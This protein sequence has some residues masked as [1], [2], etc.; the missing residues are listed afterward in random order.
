MSVLTILTADF[1]VKIQAFTHRDEAYIQC[2]GFKVL[3]VKGPE[4]IWGL[5]KSFW[6]QNGFQIEKIP[7]VGF[8]RLIGWKLKKD[9]GRLN[10]KYTGKNFGG[11]YDT[12][13]EINFA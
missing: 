3:L 12:G 11:L 4:E 10:S 13:R 8:I 1:L 2:D 5:L 9:L 6:I 7:E